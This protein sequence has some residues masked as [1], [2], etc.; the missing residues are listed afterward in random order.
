MNHPPKITAAPTFGT[1]TLEP[2]FSAIPKT[3]G[4]LSSSDRYLTAWRHRKWVWP[5]VPKARLV[6]PE[7]DGP[8]PLGP[9]YNASISDETRKRALMLIKTQATGSTT[10]QIFGMKQVGLI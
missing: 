5:V 8:E 3:T 2:D 9:S 4:W 7:P 1:P 6:F 10:A